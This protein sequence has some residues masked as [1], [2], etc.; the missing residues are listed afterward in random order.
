[1]SSDALKSIMPTLDRP[2][3]VEIWPVFEKVWTQFRS[4]PPQS[5]RFVPGST[6]MSTIQ[7]TVI[8]LAAYYIIIFGGRELMKKREK[9]FSLNGLFMAHN[10]ILTFISASL[11]ALFFEQLLP[12]VVRKGLFYAI[13]DADGG[14]TRRLVTLYYVCRV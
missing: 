3:G 8:A 13:C 2:F 4:F 6:P 7:E 1:M 12:T 5:F 14:W 11:L 10:F 9:G